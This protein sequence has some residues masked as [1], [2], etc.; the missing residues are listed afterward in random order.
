MNSKESPCT[1][2]CTAADLN[3]LFGRLVRPVINK[4]IKDTGS[5]DTRDLA[6]HNYNIFDTQV[7]DIELD[8]H[9]KKNELEHLLQSEK[10]IATVVPYKFLHSN[11]T[12]A[13][14]LERTEWL[15]QWGE[16]A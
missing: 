3:K 14:E 13:N 5:F 10:Y 9:V 6:I 16:E 7:H 2:I 1:T 8:L 15:P 11:E 12:I 4:I